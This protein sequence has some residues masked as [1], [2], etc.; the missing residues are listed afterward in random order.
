MTERIN[1]HKKAV[2]GGLWLSGLQVVTM[3]TGF[4]GSIFYARL[5]SPND[6][7]LIGIAFIFI[8]AIL[9]LFTCFR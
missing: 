1:L 7:G 4:V 2:R 8:A 9:M 6:F 3:L 5:L